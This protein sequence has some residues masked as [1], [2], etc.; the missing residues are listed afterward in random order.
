MLVARVCNLSFHRPIGGVD[1]DIDFLAGR[2]PR[3]IN[4]FFLGCRLGN[5][6]PAGIFDFPVFS[7]WRDVVDCL[8]HIRSDYGGDLSDARV[9]RN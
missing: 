3:C 9:F 8:T 5:H 1:D 7:D 2:F 4:G 6:L